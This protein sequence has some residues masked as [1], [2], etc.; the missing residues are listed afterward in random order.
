[1]LT[2]TM[3][4]VVERNDR[5]RIR[6]DVMLTASKKKAEVFARAYGPATVEERVISIRKKSRDVIERD[7]E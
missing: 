6:R 4:H 7:E 5:G 3:F 2:K 1:M